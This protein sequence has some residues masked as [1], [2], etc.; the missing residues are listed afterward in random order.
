MKLSIS[1]VDYAPEELHEQTPFNIELIR[2]IPGEDRPDYW[3]G[4]LNKPLNWNNGNTPTEITHVI[5]A[6]RWVGTKI[7]PHV[8]NIPVGIAYVTDSA[9]LHEN[10][11]DFGKCNYVAIGMATEIEGGNVSEPLNKVLSGR[12]GKFFGMGGKS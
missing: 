1:S 11:I 4:K 10:L 7:E 6:A 3:L 9:Q 8:E 2:Q 5:V 12:I